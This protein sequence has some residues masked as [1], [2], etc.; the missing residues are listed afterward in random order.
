[1][2]NRIIKESICRSDTIDRLSALEECFFYRLMVQCD[3]HGRFDGR[4]AILRG[5]CFPLKEGIS[6]ENICEM[7]QSL[8][9]AGLIFIYESDGLPYIQIVKWEKHQQVRAQRSKY[10]DPNGESIILQSSDINGLQPQAPAS[11]CPRNPIQS[12]PNPN[13]I[14]PY[15]PPKGDEHSEISKSKRKKK[16]SIPLAIEKI[17]ARIN[18]L[19]KSSWDWC[20]FTPLS[21]KYAKNVEHIGGRLR[22]GYTEADLILIAE[23]RAVADGSD[24]NSRKFYVP[25]TLYN[26][27]NVE[28][29]LALAREW[30]ARGRPSSKHRS[31]P[32]NVARGRDPSEYENVPDPPMIDLTKGANQR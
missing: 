7:L 24:E 6:N 31:G 10:P 29:N 1:M 13:P 8:A 21:S 28:G 17:L 3:D 2:P 14:P 30:D 11:R 5:S 15:S 32:R 22:D 20:Q 16:E 4:P 18:E 19:R 9:R 27:K 23:Y 25:N 12:N 26:T